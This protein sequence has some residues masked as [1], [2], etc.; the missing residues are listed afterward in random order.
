MGRLEK[1]V[2]VTR[3]LRHD[4]LRLTRQL[5]LLLGDCHHYEVAGDADL[6]LGGDRSLDHC[7][8][9][10][11]IKLSLVFLANDGLVGESGWTLR[12]H[13][14][15]TGLLAE[16]VR[17]DRPHLLPLDG[18]GV[19]DDALSHLILSRLDRV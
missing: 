5:I 9:I 14:H 12:S 11:F 2:V 17:G 8:Q 3:R 7:A 6:R 4:L 13:C 18:V 16:H 10:C 19:C 1:G 15:A